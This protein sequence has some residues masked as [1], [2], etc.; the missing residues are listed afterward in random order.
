MIEWSK[1]VNSIRQCDRAIAFDYNSSAELFIHKTQGRPA[2]GECRK[3]CHGDK[4]F[5][6]AIQKFVRQLDE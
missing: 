1:K 2:V 5:W 3:A 6:V 4:F